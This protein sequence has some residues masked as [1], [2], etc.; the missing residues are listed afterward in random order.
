MY[1]III[2]FDDIASGAIGLSGA[3]FGQGTGPIFLDNSECNPTNHSTLISCFDVESVAGVHDC[4]H[5][6][7]A[8][9]ICPGK[10]E[11]GQVSCTDCMFTAL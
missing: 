2:V 7:D 11:R 10:R 5:S 1:I 3:Y 9:V 8:S 4:E 6:E